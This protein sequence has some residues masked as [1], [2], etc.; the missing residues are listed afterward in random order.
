MKAIREV[1]LDVFWS[2]TDGW[3]TTGTIAGAVAAVAVSSQAATVRLAWDA[4]PPAEMVLGYKL[5]YQSAAAGASNVVNVG[6]VTNTAVTNIQAGVSYTYHLTAYNDAGESDPSDSL[7]HAVPLGSNEMIVNLSWDAAMHPALAYYRVTHGVTNTPGTNIDTGTAASLSLGSL[8]PGQTYFFSV[9]ALATNGAALDEYEQRTETLPAEPQTVALHLQRVPQPPQVAIVE[10]AADSIHTNPAPVRVVAQVSDRDGFV[11]RVDF[12]SGATPLPSSST[13]PFAI[14]ASLAPGIHQLSALAWDNSAMSN[15]SAA[16]RVT[17]LEPIPAVP[18]NLA[19]QPASYSAISLAWSDQSTNE[20]SFNV[21][22]S[23]PGSNYFLIAQLPAGAVAFEDTG[24]SPDTIYLY[25]VK[26]QNGTGESDAAT[27]SARTY[28]LPPPTPANFAAVATNAAVRLSWSPAARAEAYEILRAQSGGA[29]AQIASISGASHVDA[30]AANGVTYT[31]AVRARN[32]G[33]ASAASPSV[34]ATPQ[35]PPLAPAS[36]TARK[37]LN[38]ISL[39]WQDRSNNE[40]SFV[41]ERSDDG[42]A[43]S[44]LATLPANTVS[45]TDGNGIRL[46]RYWYRVRAENVG[47]ATFSN[48]AEAKLV[49]LAVQ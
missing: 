15:R 21:Y 49:G 25:G 4:N 47:G 9:S 10:P 48:V 42:T 7:T 30:T 2:G 20:S 45:Y 38:G 31:Y 11:Q 23:G 40:E 26:A 5:Y 17:V 18:G 46:T 32:L 12:Y 27:A 41:V 35:A 24:L 37:T 16:V 43:F 1:F 8:T 29:L 6:N 22:R 28:P 44:R 3:S 13:A 33:G 14:S 34:T 39:A 36:L 19:A